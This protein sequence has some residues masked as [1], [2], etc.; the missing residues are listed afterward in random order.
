MPVSFPGCRESTQQVV[1]S[2]VE[3]LTL[4][5]TGWMVRS[6]ARFLDTV[7]DTELLY[8]RAFKVTTLI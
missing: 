7:K 1:K 8:E 2:A 4:A 5:I 6:G 3:A